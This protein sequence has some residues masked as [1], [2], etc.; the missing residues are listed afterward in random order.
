MNQPLLGATAALALGAAL[1]YGLSDFLG[2]MAS[3]AQ[4]VWAVAAISQAT[5]AAVALPFAL[6]TWVAPEASTVGWAV[7]AGVGAGAG[8]VLVYHGLASGRMMVVAPVAALTSTAVPVVAELLSGR[9]PSSAAAV[10]VLAAATAVW[11][12]SGGSLRT[13]KKGEGRDLALGLLAGAGFG[14]QFTALGQVPPEAGLTPVALS[15][16]VS[17][18]GIVAIAQVRR[19]RWLPRRRSAVPMVAGAL[20]GAATL[21]F[22]LSAQS[23]ALTVAAV[24]TSLYPAVTVILA[25][26]VLR[27]HITRNQGIG[28]ALAATAVVLI[29]SG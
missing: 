11:L 21:L 8:N 6:A 1:A 15:Q 20:A 19:A 26:A 25:V 3:R 16:I 4:S 12:V 17:V 14:T 10:G 23:G 22:Q 13:M 27:E 5:A 28:L 7:L 29:R 24:V 9:P 2:G 18:I